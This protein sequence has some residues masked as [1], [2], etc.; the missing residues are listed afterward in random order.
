MRNGRGFA[1]F[2][3]LA[4]VKSCEVRRDVYCYQ[5]TL[6]VRRTMPIEFEAPKPITQTQ[7]M[8]KTVA[9]EMMRPTLAIFR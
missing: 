2:T 8:L 6:I 9:E 1:M 4:I 5:C 7:F 3:G